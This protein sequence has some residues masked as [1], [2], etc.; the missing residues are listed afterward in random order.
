M[1]VARAILAVRGT[2]RKS[3]I[4]GS[5]VHNQ[6]IERLWRDTFRCVGQ[7]YYAMFYE[8]ED[9]GCLNIDSDIDL[10]ALQFVYLPR[11][12]NQLTQFVSAWNRHPLR[13]EVHGT[14]IHY[15]L[16]VD[17][18]LYSCGI[19]DCFQHHHNFKLTLLVD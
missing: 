6:R 18:R 1:D 15:A 4:T 19:G 13:T 3:H 9:S 5:S 7:L 14:D 11:I 16:K 17:C 2:A 12:N 10:F 8:M